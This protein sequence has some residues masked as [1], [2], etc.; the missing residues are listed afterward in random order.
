MNCLLDTHTLL[1]SL[2]EP[3]RLGTAALELLQDPKQT[4]YVSV[5][6]VW[7]ISLKYSIGK[8]DLQGVTPDAF[9]DL[10]LQT[11]FELLPLAAQDAATF[12]NLARLEHKDPFDRLLIWQA[13]SHKLV[14]V[15]QDKACAAYR[16][17]GLK[18]VW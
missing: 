13:I 10:I 14:F 17:Q 18:V 7:E 15:S 5:I 2:F 1:W 4:V 8:L 16:K 6:S 12:H 11:G 9:P 3:N